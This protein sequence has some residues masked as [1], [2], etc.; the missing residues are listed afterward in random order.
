MLINK[1]IWNGDSTKLL[2][3]KT[4][5][6]VLGVNPS[7]DNFMASGITTYSFALPPLTIT[8]DIPFI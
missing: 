1:Q 2:V 6:K 8:L 4:V 7:E 5:I 3:L